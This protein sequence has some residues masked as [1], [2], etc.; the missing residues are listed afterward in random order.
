MVQVIAHRG[1]SKAAPE[2]TLEAFGL[3]RR[4]GADW[5]ELDARRTVD[6]AIVV[7]H[8]V[9]LP[10]GRIIAETQS[11]D[12]PCSVP[13]LGPAIDAC[14]GMGVNIEIK[15]LPGEAD[16][17]LSEAVAHGVAAEIGRRAN[18]SDVL[19]SSFHLPSIDRV[20]EL[21]DRVATGLLVY[22]G[23]EP[24]RLADLARRHGHQAIHP[25]DALVDE[26]L[27]AAAHQRRLAVNVWT[28]DDPVR[29]AELVDLDIDGIVTNIPDVARQVVDAV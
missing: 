27:V 8:D 15:N 22:R 3:A 18:H 17:D 10:D 28:V 29:M 14:D 2:N 25:W 20:L 12:L 11:K 19:V 7:H 21:D 23:D 26:A 9:H 24:H 5:V 1:A 4:L 13:A 16:F 6:G